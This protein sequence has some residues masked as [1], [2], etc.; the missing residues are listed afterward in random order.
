MMVAPNR[1]RFAWP[2]AKGGVMALTSAQLGLLLEGFDWR[3][4]IQRFIQPALRECS[5]ASTYRNSQKR[6]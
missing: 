4:P 3:Q 6:A 1:G 2:R 5:Y